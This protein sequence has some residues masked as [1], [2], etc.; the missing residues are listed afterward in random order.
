[1][2]M[3]GPDRRLSVA[4][5]MDCTDRH[6]RYFLRQITR[7]T[8]LYSEMVTADAV[9]YGDRAKLLGFDP[10]EHPV[11]LQLGGC[12]PEAL[13]EAAA[14]GEAW[15]YDEINL[16]VGCPSDRVQNARFGAALMAEP[17][18][19]ARCVA[20]M[21]ERVSVPVTV[22]TR[23]GIDHQDTAEFLRHFV[24]TVADAGCRSFTIHARKAWLR[25]LSPKENREKPPLIHDRA[26]ALKRARPDLEIVL[27]GG[28]DSLDGVRDALNN[29]LDGAML[30]RA[31][32]HTPWVL[33]GADAAI[34]GEPAT[35]PTRAQVVEA[36]MAYAARLRA[37]GLP[38]RMVTRHMMGLCAGL[39][40]AR[41]WRQHLS[42]VARRDDAGPDEIANA[43]AKVRDP[44]APA[45]AAA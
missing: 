32:Y 43:F 28:I 42:E 30:G 8:L 21:R 17:E 33:A 39:P 34:W 15:G 16:N 9:R 22:K 2:R 26:Y 45:A 19:V 10:I 38:I 37:Q 6:C 12:D 25:G 4:P 27:N 11:A 3:N 40:G 7:R 14:I 18:L 24:D 5:M 20:A 44:D 23:I 29:G 13:A 41:K 31:A 1:M 36:M 35:P